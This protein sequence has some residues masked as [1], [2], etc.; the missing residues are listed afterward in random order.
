[1]TYQPIIPL[2]GFAG[3]KFLE[4]TIET[5]Q[6][7][8]NESFQVQRV[9]ESFREKIGQITT[10]E[11][12]VN[13]RELLQV[14]LGA[15]GLEADIDNKYFIQKVLE[16]GTLDDDALANRLSDKSYLAMSQAF[17]F[18]DFPIPNTAL[19]TFA[20]DIIE[21]YETKSFEVAV[22]EVNDDMRLALN[23]NNSL[24][25]VVESNSG[26][27]AQWFAILG[28]PPLRAVFEAALG[29]PPS[30]GVIDIDQQLDAFKQSAR[31]NFGTDDVSELANPDD[32]DKMI[33]LF[34]LR[35]QVDT[36]SGLSSG[37]V[38]LTLLNQI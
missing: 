33:R 18:G 3:W 5:Q 34:L 28:S 16:D 30:I 12:L 25:D 13:D 11:E 21:R 19:S 17:G 35:S 23:F 10:A 4:R 14:A 31:S 15:F 2:Q 7:A 24:S 37:S 38:A 29:L 1:M 8:F 27:D 20:D 32:E 22:G 9:T 36:F 26:Q 6:Q